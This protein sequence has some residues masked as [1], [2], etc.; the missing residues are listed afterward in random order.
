[1]KKA[2]I[3]YLIGVALSFPLGLKNINRKNKVKGRNLTYRDVVFCSLLSTFSWINVAALL[4]VEAGE[5]QF[6]DKEIN[7]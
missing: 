6:L 5:S 2:I 3:I 7:L 1:M 4:T